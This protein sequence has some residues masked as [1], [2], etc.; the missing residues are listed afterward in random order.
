MIR[1]EDAFVIMPTG[2]GKSLCYQIPALCRP[3]VGIVVSP[4]ISLMK[5]QVDALRSNGVRAAFYN[6]SLDQKEASRV[7]AALHGGDLDLLYLA[8]ERLMTEAFLQRLND[9]EIS[10]FAID[11]AHCISQW[12][13]DFR[14]EYEQL[15]QLRE[16]FPDVP[17]IA[18]TATADAHTRSDIISR[19]GLGEA[20]HYVA[21]FDR[22]NIRYTVLEKRQPL[23]QLLSFIS[24]RAKHEAGIVY[25]LS[26]KRVEEVA[27]RLARAGIA[28][29]AYHAGLSD[30][31]R[32]RVHD[33]FINEEVRIVVGTVAYGMGIDKPNV[34]FVVHYDLP[35]NIE[36]FYQES[37]RA[38]RDGLPADSLVLFG[39]GDV[40][41]ARSL[42]ENSDNPEQVRIETHKLNAMIGF[43]EAL[44]CRRRILLLYFGEHLEEDCG[45]CDVCLDS[46]QRFDATEDAQ[47]ALS[48]VYRAGQRFGA[49]HI[50]DVLRGSQSQRIKALG[51][52][53]LST[54]GIG[55]SKSPE[56]WGSILHQLIHLGYLY[57]DISQY[58]ILRLTA[59]SKPLLLGQERLHL[60]RP[61]LK[62]T[63]TKEERLAAANKIKKA[64]VSVDL[65]SPD[66]QV[67]FQ[68][69]RELRSQIAREAGVPPYVVFGDVTLVEMAA[70]KPTTSEGLLK[71]SGVG[72]S[73]LG[74]YGAM[75]IAEIR[76]SGVAS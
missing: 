67:L 53:K 1:G 65:L 59:A 74:A 29:A 30:K 76:K 31:E 25:A 34:R 14:P 57:Q 75:F 27:E 24:A 43:A 56:E 8:P 20:R 61:R 12:G 70:K 46:P 10:L 38:G 47:K 50:I 55:R 21:G 51:H 52:D 40:A 60:A 48:C 36:S 22:P 28:A 54:Y 62:I 49:G 39:Y 66:E 42:I 32:S 18:L 2:G 15:G 69:L 16:L 35:K 13:H 68:S 6:S 71:I 64:K 63:Q 17:L 58:S 19:L 5:D 11:E 7:L 37:G 26:R 33:A 72:K 41:V 45:N 73:K 44:H 23:S 4:L 3:G 9:L